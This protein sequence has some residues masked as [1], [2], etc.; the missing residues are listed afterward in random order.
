MEG[1]GRNVQEI[2]LESVPKSLDEALQYDEL[3]KQ[4]RFRTGSVSGGTGMAM[5]SGHGGVADD[6]KDNLLKYFR[7]IDRGLH[8]LLRD[9]RAPLV[10]AGV[11]YLFPIYREANTYPHL[12]EEGIPGNPKG[13]SSGIASPHR[14]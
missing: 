11:E 2:E 14:P 6:T 10:L 13:T 9:E 4:V 5:V 8:D 7:L 3:E 12:I 1:T